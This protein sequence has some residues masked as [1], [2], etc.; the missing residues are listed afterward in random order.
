MG[1]MKAGTV[2]DT[3]VCHPETHDYFLCSHGGLKGTSKPTHYHV[4]YD[5]NN[6]TYVTFFLEMANKLAYMGAVVVVCIYGKN[7][8]A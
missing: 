7:S 8:G 6:F 3:G 5:E 1:N 2:I 4:M